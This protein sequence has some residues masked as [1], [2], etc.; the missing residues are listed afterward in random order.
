MKLDY[1]VLLAGHANQTA[2]NEINL[3]LLRVSP[4][5]PFFEVSGG[6]QHIRQLLGSG[7]LN[8]VFLSIEID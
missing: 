6:A 2:S 8:F 3:K 1:S 4:V 5:R 7:R